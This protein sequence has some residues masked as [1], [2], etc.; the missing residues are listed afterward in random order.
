[1]SLLALGE[2]LLETPMC[3]RFVAEPVFAAT[4]QLLQER[5]PREMASYSQGSDLAES[6][7]QSDASQMPVR[8]FTAANTPTPA[9]QLLSNGRYHVML[10]NAGGG[11]SRW[12]NLAVTRW[13]ED[14]T[15]DNWG[16]FC[17][18]RDVDSGKFWSNTLQPTCG[19]CTTYE[20]TFTEPRVQFHRRDDEIETHTDIAVSPEDDIELR[21][22]RITNRSRVRRT[23]EV[24]SYA[25]VVLAP[26]MADDTGQAFS[27]L[28][29]ETEIVE[30]RAAI[31][32]KRRPRSNSEHWP[33]M[34][35]LV[36][37]HG[38]VSSETSYETDRMRFI[39]RGNSVAEPAAMR[40]TTLSGTHGAVLDPV[41]AIRHRFTLE[42]KQSATL[43][44]VTGIAN[45]RAASLALA[46]KYHDQNLGDRV[47]DLAWTHAQVA[48]RQINVTEAEAQL[49]GRLAGRVVY[50]NA[51][52]RADSKLIAG[53]RRS[54][55]DLWRYAISGD[56]PILLLQ[57]TDAANIELVRQLVQAHAY[58]RS[59]GLAV[60]LVILN[61]D[62]GGY[63]QALQDQIIGM[64]SAGVGGNL[65]DRPG[66]IFV[67]PAEQIAAEDRA[68]LLSVARAIIS[69]VN[70]SLLE[71]VKQR[72][73]LEIPI[74]RFVATRSERAAVAPATKVPQ[75]ELMFDNGIGG[76]SATGR[77]YVITTGKGKVTPLPWANVLANPNFGT[78][79][80]ETGAAYTWAENAHEYRLS[81]W[82]ND[83]VCDPSGE[84]FYLRDEETGRFWSPTPA[85]C[86]GETPY[87]TRHGFG[88]SAFEH[89]EDGIQTE[90]WT[91]VALDAPV[92]FS[93][94]RLKNVSGRSRQL[95]LTGY[96]EWVL[97]DLRQ[98]SATHVVTSIDPDCGALFARNSYNGEFAD[99]VAFFDLDDPLRTLS[100]DRT[101]F[102]GRNGSLQKPAAL[103]RGR[104]S[105]KVGA[106]LDPCAAIQTS[107]ELG[108]GQSREVIFRLGA[109]EGIEKTSDLV[110]RLR[111]PG[112]ARDTFIAVRDFWKRTLGVIQVQTPN[113]EL[114]V[115]ANGWLLYQTIACRLWGRSGYYQSGG[116]YGFRDQLQDSM[117]L[118]FAA[119]ALLRQQI[120]RSAG[121]QFKEGDV[122]HWWHPP[123]GRGVRTRCSDDY[124]WLPLAVWRYV[125]CTG[126]RDVLNERSAFLEGRPVSDGEESYYDLPTTSG[127]SVDLYEHCVR[128]IQH[129]LNFGAHGLPLMGSGDWNDGM[130]NVGLH[131][132]GESVWL[133]FFL[134]QVLV[135]FAQIADVR[136]DAPFATRCRD[137]ARALS[138][139]IEQNAWDGAWYRR[140]YF[141]DGTPL[142]SSTDAECRIDSIAQSWS[143][144]SGA[145][146][147][148]RRQMAMESLDQHL[149]DR[150]HRLIKLLD[151]PFD[152]S[153]LDPGYI[154][155]YVPGVRENGG[156]YTHA[157]IWASMAFAALGDAE[158]ANELLGFINPVTHASSAQALEV[159][160]VEPYVVTAD[161][162]AVAPHTGRGGWS[163]YTGSAGWLYRL[164]TE[165]ILGLRLDGDKLHIAPCVPSDWAG[166]KITYMHGDTRYDLAISRSQDAQLR[167]TVDGVEQSDRTITLAQDGKTRAVA[168]LLPANKIDDGNESRK[169]S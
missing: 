59:K 82:Q 145:A 36:A 168:V 107:F 167:I 154:K 132:K 109:G 39:G 111:Q 106:T 80:S 7:A 68:L 96:V 98:K 3:K 34:L 99:R 47:F 124:L 100:G 146:A 105:G 137:E 48:L 53:N 42:P 73:L 66:G 115:L 62:H 133:A 35:H 13:R 50:A 11:S 49:Y 114:D 43:D 52:L 69:D 71:Q 72:D 12:N 162:Y 119:P 169:T 121:R 31:V 27:N 38:A 136:A 16:T 102:I 79:V 63:R 70:G 56:L 151:P 4:L 81:P 128:A 129:G 141:D 135:N 155:G 126:D 118:V 2:T 131:G 18:V 83:P 87:V 77:E 60:D 113:R 116:A 15:R 51:S 101:E 163:W 21:R 8:V 28:F 26:P 92:K 24:T 144:L 112:T 94:I 166:Y 55:S 108:D 142:G 33:S 58:W 65:I 23:I 97:G 130:N 138:Q 45:D 160:K 86:G 165:S 57:I 153:P 75:R 103:S 84:A 5:V 40:A 10:T 91:Y 89:T 30:S 61:D 74:P 104:L 20:A 147:N 134:H 164:M 122:Q 46:E 85:P 32:C 161:V 67:R 120:L 78:V 150:E 25:E 37:L 143:V 159:F 90:L 22:V 110:Q 117:A 93:V 41:V 139:H 158:R 148:D 123:S 127:D 152:K 149:V 9:I 140:A 64:I 17:Y 19:A 14:S 54:Q 156:Q 29:V 6:R 1:M 125:T 44:I 88:Y 157:A 76:F 95:S